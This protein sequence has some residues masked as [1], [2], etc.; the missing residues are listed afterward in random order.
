MTEIKSDLRFG[1]RPGDLDGNLGAC[2]VLAEEGIDWFQEDRLPSTDQLR[3]FGVHARVSV[4]VET[5][6]I[7]AVDAGEVNLRSRNL[8][9][10]ARKVKDAVVEDEGACKNR[11]NVRIGLGDLADF[12][13][14]AKAEAIDLFLNLLVGEVRG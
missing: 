3:N 13:S 4:K 14:A 10:H 7:E 6:A 8:E 2:A 12:A 11:V 9:V 1:L 5:I